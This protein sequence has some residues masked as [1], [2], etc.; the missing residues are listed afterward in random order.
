MKILL[1]NFGGYSPDPGLLLWHGSNLLIW[2]IASIDIHRN[3]FRTQG[4]KYLWLSFILLFG[5]IGAV[6]YLFIRKDLI[7]KK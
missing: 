7:Q 2:I 1:L 6:F 3:K 5:I 4:K